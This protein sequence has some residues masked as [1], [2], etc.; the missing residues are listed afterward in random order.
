MERRRPAVAVEIRQQLFKIFGVH[1]LAL[2]FLDA[3][4]GLDAFDPGLT[5]QPASGPAG[6]LEKDCQILSEIHGSDYS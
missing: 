2:A 3:S 5:S 6:I 1:P 4:Y